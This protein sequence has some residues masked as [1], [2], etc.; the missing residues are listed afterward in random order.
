MAERTALAGGRMAATD[1]AAL[2]VAAG[3]T[4]ALDRGQWPR[5]LIIALAWFVALAAARTRAVDV[6]GTGR[7]QVDRV[8][9]ATA[10][11]F[12]LLL[13]ADAVRGELMPRVYLLVMLPLG[14]AGVIGGRWFWRRRRVALR[15]TGIERNR[16]LVIGRRESV[17]A[18]AVLLERK[19]EDGFTVVAA[20]SAQ[21]EPAGAPP[22]VV[23]D[24]EIP[25]LGGYRD[26]VEAVRASGA[27]AVALWSTEELGQDG[28][29]DL[30][31]QL[32]SADLDLL[33][34]PGVSGVSAG[35]LAVRPLADLP[36]IQVERPRYRQA[37]ALGKRVFDL[38]FAV[39]AVVV[40]AP[41]VLAAAAAVKLTSPG[42]AFYAGVRIGIDG[43]PFRMFK[44][45][46]M[47]DGA[48]RIRGGL[49]AAN[50][51]A[52]PLFKLHEDPRVT[53]V[54]KW[55]R[56]TSI[57]ELPQF[58]NVLRGEMSVVGPRPPLPEEVA[59]YDEIVGR[60]LLVRPGVTGAWQVSGRS[61]LPWAESIRLD[62]SYVENWSMVE[63]LR[64]VLRT[65]K[66][67]STRDG[68]Y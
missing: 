40:S 9:N 12:G 17:A 10:V 66:A 28:V 53:P 57:D 55:L 2:L 15:R 63:D 37:K 59:S 44:L 30:M 27:D 20:C 67:V 25:F 46:T 19:A 43:R 54:G 21:P 14:V 47:V 51:A 16:I 60:R 58:I 56:R 22:V 52:G 6:I 39:L 38:G 45:R 26:V 24:R 33:L 65:V 36:F 35:R 23:G 42:P 7:M 61:S 50:Q 64:I 31:W 13:L 18:L 11:L 32:E 68:A 1:A 49:A 62:L 29:R 48:D 8:L 4:A 3:V 34:V 41:L 5:V